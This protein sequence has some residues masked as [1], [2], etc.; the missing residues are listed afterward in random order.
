MLPPVLG[1]PMPSEISTVPAAPRTAP[2]PRC[3]SG[4]SP[5]QRAS[6]SRPP[7]SG[8]WLPGIATTKPR[9][10]PASVGDPRANG[11]TG[12]SRGAQKL[13]TSAPRPS[14]TS[15][16]PPSSTRAPRR[17]SWNGRAR[18]PRRSTPSPHPSCCR[19]CGRVRRRSPPSG[20]PG[21]SGPAGR[22]WQL[23]ATVPS[24]P[25]PH[26]QVSGR[27]LG[28]QS[29]RGGPQGTHCDSNIYPTA[30]RPKPA[31]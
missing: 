8:F 10:S 22:G 28:P 6:A 4:C 26:L 16:A 31:S 24:P 2:G 7:P 12:P 5:G 3:H 17:T 19:P 20:W 23:I 25:S 11:A 30:A 29:R 13:L 15:R 14:A 18:L 9:P 21:P 1:C 27:A